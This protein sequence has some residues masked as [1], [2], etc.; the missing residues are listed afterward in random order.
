VLE[1][2]LRAAFAAQ[3]RRLD[4]K[5]PV[6]DPAGTAIRRARRIRSRRTAATGA[7]AVALLVATLGGAISLRGWYLPEEQRQANLARLA[8][9]APEPK[10]TTARAEAVLPKGTPKLK[11]PP[12]SSPAALFPKDGPSLDI[13][14]GDELWTSAGEKM[15]LTGAGEVRWVYRVPA[16]WV[17]GGDRQVRLLRPSGGS[18]QLAEVDSA[19]ALTSVPQPAQQRQPKRSGDAAAQA[20]AALPRWALSPDGKRIAFAAGQK[21]SV[22]TIS[23]GG[24][25]VQQSTF[26]AGA[27][28][29][30]FFGDSVVLTTASADQYDIWWTDRQYAA[31]PGGGITHVYGPYGNSLLGLA[32]DPAD[33]GRN[34]LVLIAPT[35]D[36][37][38][39]QQSQGCGLGLASGGLVSPDGRWIAQ[40]DKDDIRLFDVAAAMRG[41][42]RTGTCPVSAGAVPVW[43]SPSTLIA[44]DG[45]QAVRC[46]VTGAVESYTPPA[47]LPDGWQFVPSLLDT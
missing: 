47:G 38:L 29:V 35:A 17:Y 37:L 3:A 20:P 30:L 11:S 45:Y 44:V 43:E 46:T 14:A 25:A 21:V 41:S 9:T 19:P 23:A 22:G 16:G 12:P 1:D 27:V 10:P 2:E 34:C 28:P 13:V 39:P 7:A 18:I 33:A 8:T 26:A 40:R 31:A 6:V 36:G 15:R 24:L 42:S 32:P 4:A 5:P